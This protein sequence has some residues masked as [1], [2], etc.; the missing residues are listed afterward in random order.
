VDSAGLGTGLSR[1]PEELI[2]V[3][4]GTNEHPATRVEEKKALHRCK[5]LI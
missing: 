1:R 3:A 5:A 4:D 2:E